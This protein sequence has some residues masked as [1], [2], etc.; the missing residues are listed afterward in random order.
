MEVR[1]P[2]I[3]QN[4]SVVSRLTFVT[5]N[6]YGEKK[7]R[8]PLLDR[9][10]ERSGPMVFLQE[11]NPSRAFR[12]LSTFRKKAFVSVGR[13]GLQY[14]VTVLP[15][16]ARFIEARTL[17]LNGHRGL[18]P[19][20]RSVRRA[21]GLYKSGD[22]RWKDCF[23][24]RIAQVCQVSWRG[25]EFQVA[26]T[27]LSLETGLRN[28][29]FSRLE[30]FLDGDKV[31]VSGDLNA[32]GRDL[33]LNDFVLSGRLNVAGSGEATHVSGRRIDYVLYRGGFREVGYSTQESLSDHRLLTV[34]LEV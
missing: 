24:P 30:K 33:F 21:Y 13:H 14:L 29:S 18:I 34:D 15:A 8:D 2:R 19:T 17:Q 5:Y 12:T 6:T 31:V 11:V 16:D 25:L 7:G 26:N 1:F 28:D 32:V 23:E 20:F 10:L 22:K 9:T 27:H 4:G 3:P